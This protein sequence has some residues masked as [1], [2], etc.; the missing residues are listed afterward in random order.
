[1][2]GRAWAIA[3]L[4]FGILLACNSQRQTVSAAKPTPKPVE[5]Q[6]LFTPEAA[7]LSEQKMCDEQA[8]KKFREYAGANTPISSYTSRYDPSV[9]L[10]YVRVLFMNGRPAY[11]TDTVYDAFGGRVYAAY[12]WTEKSG[13]VPT[14]CKIFIPGESVQLCKST[15]E[16]NELVGRYFG[17]AQ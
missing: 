10:C 17:V 13:D 12:G 9:N 16:F 8:A 14:M 5:A 11:A 1:M 7:S 2:K 3:Y 6:P 15:T 4:G